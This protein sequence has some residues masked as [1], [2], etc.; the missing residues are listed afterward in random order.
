MKKVFLST[1]ILLG[2]S[3]STLIFQASCKK[4]ATADTKT[5]TKSENLGILLIKKRDANNVMKLYTS[6]YEG[7]NIKLVNINV[8]EDIEE[9]QLSPDGK[10]II[11]SLHPSVDIYKCSID[12]SN[13]VKILDHSDTGYHFEGVY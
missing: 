2:F 3:L 8:S 9:A 1:L 6:D 12:G 10:T 5:T 13:L 11:F 4:E 7:K